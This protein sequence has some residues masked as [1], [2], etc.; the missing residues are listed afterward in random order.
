M[1]YQSTICSTKNLTEAVKRLPEILRK[2][3]YKAT[4]DVSFASGDIVNE[5]QKVAGQ[6]FKGIF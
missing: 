1:D 5:I 6:S 3:F 4:K 2:L